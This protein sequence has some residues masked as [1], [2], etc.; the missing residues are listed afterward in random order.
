[1]TKRKAK[2]AAKR[3]TK[4]KP[5]AAPR[6]KVKPPTTPKRAAP[7]KAGAPRKAGQ[8]IADQ[9]KKRLKIYGKSLKKPTAHF[10]GEDLGSFQIDVLAF[11]RKVGAESGYVLIT[12]GMSDHRPPRPD[13]DEAYPQTELVWFTRD[14]TEEKARFLYW[15]S[16]QPFETGK[17]VEFGAFVSAPKPPVA[18]CAN[19]GI[20]FLRPITMSEKLMHTELALM[21]GYFELFAIHLLSDSEFRHVKKSDKRFNEFMDLLDKNKYPLFLDPKRPSYV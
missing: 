8:L 13:P 1:M 19:K 4:P 15:L 14:A 2:A 18:G 21:S 11:P 9:R 16:T 17:P 5:K 3:A 7:K 12:N 6:A 20:T 10:R